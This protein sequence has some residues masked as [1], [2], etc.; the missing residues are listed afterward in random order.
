MPA[1][2][3]KGSLASALLEV[4]KNL[5]SLPKDATNPHFKNK[6]VSLETLLTKVIPVLNEQGLVFVQHPTTLDGQPALRTR[7]I[8]AA[9]GE[10]EEDTMYLLGKD[11]PQGQ[12]AALTYARR[13]AMTAVLGL[14]GDPDDDGNRAN[15]QPVATPESVRAELADKPTDRQIKAGHTIADKL[16]KA[17][18]FTNA[19]FIESLGKEYGTEHLSELSKGQISDLLS[20]LKA[21]E[22]ALEGVPA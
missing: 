13:Y 2:T 21:K 7:I 10:F 5:P 14:G 20:R 11:D 6:Y 19:E 9:S 22:K 17:G 4:Q 12:G 18:A 1:T 16:I 15:G 8:H 3:A